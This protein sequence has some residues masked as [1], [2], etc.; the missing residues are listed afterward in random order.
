MKGIHLKQYL[1]HC[2]GFELFH[3]ESECWCA[4]QSDRFDLGDPSLS[5]RVQAIGEG[6]FRGVGFSC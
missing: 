3:R 5:R 1:H 6:R 2:G 4:E